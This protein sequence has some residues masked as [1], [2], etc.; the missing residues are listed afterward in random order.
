MDA[1]GDSRLQ[2][3]LSLHFHNEAI[4]HGLIPHVNQTLYLP[5]Q[6]SPIAC[7]I[8]TKA[9]VTVQDPMLQP[10]ICVAVWHKRMH[11]LRQYLFCNL[12]SFAVALPSPRRT[13]SIYIAG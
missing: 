13:Y 6:H 5:L 1:G 12:R 4:D 3:V 9:A 2:T 8:E 10:G 11:A 7:S